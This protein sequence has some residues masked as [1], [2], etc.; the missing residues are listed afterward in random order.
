MEGV[1]AGGPFLSCRYSGAPASLIQPAY[2]SG[3]SSRPIGIRVRTRRTSARSTSAQTSPLCPC[4]SVRTSPCGLATSELPGNSS[5]IRR[6]PMC[7]RPVRL[8][9]TTKHWDS[10]ARPRTSAPPRGTWIRARAS[11]MIDRPAPRAWNARL[12][13][14]DVLRSAPTLAVHALVGRTLLSVLPPG[15]P[16]RMGPRALPLTWSVSHLL[17]WSAL[18]VQGAWLEGAF[19]PV[20][21]AALLLPWAA[22]ALSRVVTLPGAMV[23]RYERSTQLSPATVGSIAVLVLASV[24]PLLAGGLLGAPVSETTPSGR[25]VPVPSFFTSAPPPPALIWQ[26]AFVTLAP[27]LSRGLEVLRRVPVWRHLLVAAL[28]LTPAVRSL[29]GRPECASAALL[30]GSVA[31]SLAWLRRADAR[32]R[33]VGILLAAALPA[34]DPAN[35]ALAGTVL[36]ALT[37]LTPLPARRRT[38]LLSGAAWLIGARSAWRAGLAAPGF[39]WL[40][41][42]AP[43]PWLVWPAAAA[44]GLVAATRTPRTAGRARPPGRELVYLALVIALGTW[45]SG[46]QVAD[47]APETQ[48][49]LVACIV[50]V[51]GL[52]AGALLPAEREAPD[53]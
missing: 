44:L 43:A 23:P 15:A 26:V 14:L 8:H 4:P 24:A 21:D 37:V 41:L 11:W 9:A 1:A 32:G 45:T 46:W 36:A 42:P 53:R 13:T 10:T 12:T 50:P 30:A 25:H 2:S 38:A 3:R 52:L 7:A 39:A 40:D 31:A 19:G 29:A 35:L 17:G 49:R 22:V 18:T 20:S 48:L 5:S 34:F 6:R 28:L 33:A 51:L 16:G 27:V 47:P